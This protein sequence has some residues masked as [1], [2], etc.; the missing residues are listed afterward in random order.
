MHGDGVVARLLLLLLHG[1]DDVDHPLPVAGDP[2]L[3]PAVEVKLPDLPALVFL[4]G[5]GKHSRSSARQEEEEK[6][7]F[8]PKKGQ[9][10]A[11]TLVLVTSRSRTV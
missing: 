5:G 2:N 8:P 3:G 4:G 11:L 9:G 1:R 7:R 6:L 10:W